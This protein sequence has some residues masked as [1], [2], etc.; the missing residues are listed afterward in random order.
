MDTPIR[1]PSSGQNVYHRFKV[2]F[3]A[4][5]CM[6][7]F[8][9]KINL[10]RLQALCSFMYEIQISRVQTSLPYA[11]LDYFLDWSN[12]ADYK[13]ILVKFNAITYQYEVVDE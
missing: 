2:S 5:N 7:K 3:G 8:M 11:N 13:N 12:K 4:W 9:E 1:T 6:A 10:L